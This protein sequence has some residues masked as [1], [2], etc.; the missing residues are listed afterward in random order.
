MLEGLFLFFPL[1]CIPTID[2]LKWTSSVAIICISIFVVIA[3]VMGIIQV[4]KEV[5]CWS[6]LSLVAIAV[7][8]VPRRLCWI[9]YICFCV[10]HMSMR[11]C[12]HSQNDIRI[13]VPFKV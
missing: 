1:L 12:E 10:L 11:S 2:S 8:L 13:E 6:V 7:Q 9:E 5:Q 4:F 3:I